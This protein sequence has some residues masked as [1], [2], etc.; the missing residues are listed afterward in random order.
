M[1]RK[2]KTDTIHIS[3]VTDTWEKEICMSNKRIC[4]FIFGLISMTLMQCFY[5]I[6]LTDALIH[7][8]NMNLKMFLF[9]PMIVALIY[10][11]CEKNLFSVFNINSIHYGRIPLAIFWI[12]ESVIA[13]IVSNRTVY[14]FEKRDLFRITILD[15]SGLCLIIGVIL[16]ISFLL[17]RTFLYRKEDK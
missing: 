17:C 14:N 8:T 7:G 5:W 1:K 3:T 15:K 9:I 4:V 13:M 2:I 6:W 11:F 10:C 12:I 16:M